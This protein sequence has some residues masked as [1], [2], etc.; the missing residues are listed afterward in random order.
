MLYFVHRATV[1]KHNVNFAVGVTVLPK[2]AKHK[3]DLYTLFYIGMYFYLL[4]N[5]QETQNENHMLMV[6]FLY[7]N[8]V[9]SP[10]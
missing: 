3:R 1:T 4:W 6:I 10:Y 2:F 9:A 7:S 8:Y 5:V